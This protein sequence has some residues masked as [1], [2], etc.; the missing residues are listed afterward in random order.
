MA[1]NKKRKR[2]PGHGSVIQFGPA[3]SSIEPGRSKGKPEQKLEEKPGE[4]LEEKLAQKP[5]QKPAQK[6]NNGD[7]VEA[8]NWTLVGKH[9]KK[10]KT[11]NHPALI[12]AELHTL[13]SAIST[14]DLRDLALYCL[15]DGTSPQWISVRHHFD[16]KKAVILCVPGLE[17]GMFEGSEVLDPVDELRWHDCFA[18]KSNGQKDGG[19]E[20][21]FSSPDGYLPMDLASVKLSAPLKPLG[22]IFDW[23]WPVKAPGDDRHLNLYSPLYSMLYSPIPKSQEDKRAEKNMK[24]PKPVDSSRWENRRTRVDRYIASKEELLA[25]NYKLHPAWSD[26]KE[27]KVIE[28]RRRGENKQTEEYGWVDTAVKELG[29]GVVP[30][31]EIEE[32]SV[33][34]GHTVL[35]VD[36]EMCMVEGDEHALTRI[37]V[38]DWN[39]DVLMDELVKPERPITDYLTQSDSL[40]FGFYEGADAKTGSRYSGITQEKLEHIYTSLSDIQGRLLKLISPRTI[41]VG[42]SL[43]SDLDALKMT[44]PFVIDTSLIYPHHRGL[45][46][47]NSL[48]WLAQKYLTREIQKGGQLGHNSVEDSLAC[49]DLVKMKCEKGPVWGTSEAG[50]ESIFKRLFRTSQEG[51]LDTDNGG[52]GKTGAI[53]DYGVHE[54]DFAQMASTRIGCNSDSEVVEGVIRAALGS[55]DGL[56]APGGVDFTWARLRELEAYRGWIGDDRSAIS[57]LLDGQAFSTKAQDPSAK[58]LS[59]SVASTVSKISNIHFNLPPR[60]LFI[61]YSGSGDPKDLIRLKEMRNTFKREYEQQK[62]RWEDLSVKWTDNEQQSLARA[63]QKARQGI[64]FV[65]IT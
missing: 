17:R 37:S 3:F 26:S 53:V 9:G 1:R 54:K 27:E 50:C 63:F 44:H 61:V 15:A 6:S 52:L 23:L 16:V 42:H 30:E 19:V 41:V 35:A 31:S 34:A 13:R 64:G 14:Y 22:D 60:T 39:G 65:T 12:Y 38:V 5:A 40:A 24:G 10:R 45:P 36:C 55:L 7:E 8:E 58:S 46:F 57:K 62:I 20:R 43:N 59:A 33:T 2:S 29:D 28:S 25:N 18:L 48:R 11:D 56:V 32:G 21:T 47:K 49:M 51:T 4:K